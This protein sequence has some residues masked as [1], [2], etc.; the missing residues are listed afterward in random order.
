MLGTCT[1]IFL[2][3]GLIF[4]LRPVRC[5]PI[6]VLVEVLIKRRVAKPLNKLFFLPLVSDKIICKEKVLF[7]C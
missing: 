2:C 1:E 5:D 4:A 3:D 7:H 6:L